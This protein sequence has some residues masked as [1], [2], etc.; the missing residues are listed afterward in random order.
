L[1]R[2]LNYW[3]ALLGCQS[4][5][6]VD[7][8]GVAVEV[9]YDDRVDATPNHLP[10]RIKIWTQRSRIEIVQAHTNPSANCGGRQINA[11]VPW[12][13]DCS[14]R[15]DQSAERQYQRGC[16]AVGEQRITRAIAMQQGGHDAIMPVWAQAERCTNAAY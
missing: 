1:R 15:R 12:V 3:N 6:G 16:P 5:H 11:S 13:R 9:R 2:I 10:H 4:F 7:V 14:S 8:R